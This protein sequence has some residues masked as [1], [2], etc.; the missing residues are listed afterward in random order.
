MAKLLKHRGHIKKRGRNYC[1]VMS[2]GYKPDGRRIRQWETVGP[3]KKA[4]EK[5]LAELLRELDNG[6]YV[7]PTKETLKVFM[8]DWLAYVKNNLAASTHNGYEHIVRKH[9][10]QSRLANIPLSQITTAHLRSYFDQKLNGDKEGNSKLSPRTVRHHYMVLREAMQTALQWG[11]VQR[12]I[13]D[14]IAPPKCKRYEGRTI[15]KKDMGKLLEP[16]QQTDYYALFFTDIHTGMRL[17]EILG[18]RW[19]DIDFLLNEIQ[20]R[21]TLHRYKGETIIS[22]TK[23]AGSRRNIKMTAP[24]RAVL[25]DHYEMRK[26]VSAALGCAFTDDSYVFCHDDGMPL[27]PNSVS[28]AWTKLVRKVGL[29]GVRFHDCRHNHATAL[30]KQ[31]LHPKIVSEMLG[32]SSVMITLDMYSHVTPSLQEEAAKTFDEAFSESLGCS[33]VAKEETEQ[34]AEVT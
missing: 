7:K 3:D 16:A 31:K 22:D 27:L 2:T 12:N 8:L 10:N 34:L 13:L 18:L 26:G 33:R 28:H 15:S 5:R 25:L 14:T 23:T 4:A 32:H 9:I 19:G 24:S 6:T 21:R 11:R 1:I 30:F 29:K 17:S 20:V